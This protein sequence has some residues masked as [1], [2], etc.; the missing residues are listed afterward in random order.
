MSLS[1]EYL[2]G[3][4]YANH[5]AAA[6]ARIRVRTFQVPPIRDGAVLGRL[7]PIGREIML[8]TLHLL[9]PEPFLAID[10]HDDTVA[11]IIVRKAILLRISPQSLEKIVLH[12]IKPVMAKTEILAL[13]LEIEMEL[14]EN[15]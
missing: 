14:G 8:E 10:V 1:K 6:F 11:S 15:F 7:A 2:F 3:T 9:S 4:E 13:H 5:E 12:S